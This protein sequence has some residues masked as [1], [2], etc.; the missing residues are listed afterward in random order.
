MKAKILSLL[1]VVALIVTVSIFTVQAADTFDPAT[2][3]CSHCKSAPADGWVQYTGQQVTGHYYLSEDWTFG[4]QYT[5]GDGD[6]ICLYI[7]GCTASASATTQAFLIDKGTAEGA[8][9]PELN[10]MGTG[11]LTGAVNHTMGSGGLIYMDAN[12]GILNIYDSVTVRTAA[13]GCTQQTYGGVIYA[14]GASTEINMYGGAIT[15]GNPASG[16]TGTNGGAVY[17]TGG[18]RLTMTAGTITGASSA[19]G[20]AVNVAGGSSLTMSG[21][22]AIVGG[23]ASRMGGSVYA[24]GSATTVNINGGSI[25]GGIQSGARTSTNYYGGGAV[26]LNDGATM[27]MTAGTV[28]GS[29]VNQDGGSV[30]LYNGI[31]NMTGG[32]I[33]SAAN[34]GTRGGAIYMLGANSQLTIGK[35]GNDEKTAKVEG[36]GKGFTNGGLICNAAGTVNIYDGAW[37]TAGLSGAANNTGTGGGALFVTGTT[38]IYGGLIEGNT[39]Y[40]YGGNILVT[41]VGKL[42]ISGGTISGGK[43]EMGGNIFN[44]GT[45]KIT[46]GILSDGAATDDTVTADTTSAVDNLGG[47][48]YNNTNTVTISG[49]E[50]TGGTATNGG[51]IYAKVAVTIS[52]GTITGGSA[53]NGGNIYAAVETTVSGGTVTGGTATNGG[54]IY[55]AA[56]LT[57]SDGT[58]TSGT[59]TS[60]GNIYATAALTVS[61]G[62]ITKGTAENGGN[63]YTNA[64]LDMTGGTISY[65]SS[66]KTIT[67]TSYQYYGGGNVFLTGSAA[68][69]TMNGANALVTEGDAA[70]NGGNIYL[71]SSAKFQL[72]TGTV[73][74]GAVAY[75]GTCGLQGGGNIHATD[76]ATTVDIDGGTIIGGTAMRGGNIAVVNNADL[77]VNA[78]AQLSVT[79][80]MAN[81]AWLGANIFARGSGS[82]YVTLNGGTVSGATADY[83]DTDNDYGGNIYLHNAQLTIKEGATVTGGKAYSGGNIYLSQTTSK[84]VFEGGTISAG[85]SAAAPTSESGV[86]NAGGGNIYMAA[87]TFTMNGENAI[88]ENG[89]AYSGGNVRISA[90][91]FDMDNGI[92]RNGTAVYAGKNGYAGGG[93]FMVSGTLDVDGGTITGGYSPVRG[94]N[95]YVLNTEAVTIHNATVSLADDATDIANE[96]G[97]IY[98]RKASVATGMTVGEGAVITCG[99]NACSGNGRNILVRNGT[100]TLA[101]GE[102]L[103]GMTGGNSVN[104]YAHID[105]TTDNKVILAGDA[106][107]DQLYIQGAVDAQANVEIQEGFEGFVQLRYADGTIYDAVTYGYVLTGNTN[108]TVAEA[109]ANTGSIQ[110]GAKVNNNATYLDAVYVSDTQQLA[111]AGYKKTDA[112]G[113]SSFIVDISEVGEGECLTLIRDMELTL[114][115]DMVVDTNGYDVTITTEN[116]AKVYLIDLT[117]DETSTKF[118][119]VTVDA[120][121][122]GDVQVLFNG[123]RYIAVMGE[124]GTYTA[125][126]LVLKM[127]SVVLRTDTAGIYYRVEIRCDRYLAALVQSYGVALSVQ[128]MPDETFAQLG[129]SRTD[130]RYTAIGKCECGG[131]CK[132]PE[133]HFQSFVSGVYNSCALNNILT[134]NIPT[135]GITNAQR[136]EMPVYANGYVT[137]VLPDGTDLILMTDEVNKNKSTSSADWDAS[138]ATAYSIYDVM[139]L[140]DDGFDSFEAKDQSAIVEF[141]TTWASHITDWEL[142][143]IKAAYD[144]AQE[145]QT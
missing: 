7:D 124:D 25:T 14:G 107:V 112:N 144:A 1:L 102:I 42:N 103:N 129:T 139:K 96:G 58:I 51:S 33:Q 71:M 121:S 41:T 105:S 128:S 104:V 84:V 110:V 56:A 117:N 8:V 119:E 36:A 130:V 89:Q 79:T 85:V 122:L 131:T 81:V 63:I 114:S 94:G 28:Q 20:G 64:A 74:N 77:N 115:Q 55:A 29:K 113:V 134:A 106:N 5:V 132:T 54:N 30:Y 15:A 135:G 18:A 27:T 39:C 62:T 11:T 92:V 35:A 141:Y 12:G 60:G 127:K 32:T 83:T 68:V 19:W 24:T 80:P 142:P 99:E 21:T 116:G 22:A 61:G 10:I 126:K 40:T 125:H 34:G 95:I 101:G 72:V 65:G 86:Q 52:G 57:V 31:L 43:A 90:G 97:N 145:S 4:T 9:T 88:I 123:A 3:V 53:T 50:I 17:L 109:Y 100:L 66:T 76:G 120:A 143:K 78:G 59:A 91:T 111:V 87:G 138:A 75:T 2:T 45:T 93:N 136:G 16:V 69:F 23:T 38:N 98:I 108:V 70:F 49:G 67:D 48:I 26:Y 44:N 137:I 47:N 6:K 37:L 13:S 46:G 73:S 140:I 133:I 82:C 118:G